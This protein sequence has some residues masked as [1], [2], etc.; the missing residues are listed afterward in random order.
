M[1]DEQGFTLVELLAAL[2]VGALLLVLLS[3]ISA[4]VGHGLHDPPARR[5]LQLL[6][7]AAPT[8]RSFLERIQPPG[9]NGIGFVGSKSGLTAIISPPQALGAIGPLSLQLSVIQKPG[10]AALTLHLE[11]R[12][13]ASLPPQLATGELLSGFKS[14]RFSYVPRARTVD[15]PKLIMIGLT[16]TQGGFHSIDVAPRLTS[17]G[18]CQFD[19]ISMACRI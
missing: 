14:I 15:V 1:T 10:G 8:L 19:P 5:N 7:S 18:S 11:P 2:V 9:R 6:S 17:D 12:E 16:D 13:T 4:S 3:D